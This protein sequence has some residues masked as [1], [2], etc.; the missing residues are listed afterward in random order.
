[1]VFR[2]KWVRSS[3]VTTSQNYTNQ[4][5]QGNMNKIEQLEC[6]DNYISD[7]MSKEELRELVYEMINDD[8]LIRSFKMFSAV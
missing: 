7:K 6:I 2:I 4:K 8:S 1:M 3:L 5:L